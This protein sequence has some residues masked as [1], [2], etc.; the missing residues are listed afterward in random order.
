MIGKG[1]RGKVQGRQTGSKGS[2][3][4]SQQSRRVKE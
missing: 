3:G 4:P 2:R 1:L